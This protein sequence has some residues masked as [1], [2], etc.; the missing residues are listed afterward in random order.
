MGKN[1]NHE[2]LKSRIRKGCPHSPLLFNIVLEFLARVIR[3]E[4]ETKG[5]QIRK[6]ND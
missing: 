5:G 3:Q 2:K 4:E 1:R 6:K